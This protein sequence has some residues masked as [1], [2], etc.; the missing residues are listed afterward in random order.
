MRSVSLRSAGASRLR[1]FERV[2]R[3]GP[4]AR[5]R[6]I[7]GHTLKLLP[8]RHVQV[9]GDSVDRPF[10][11]HS[12]RVAK[13]GEQNGANENRVLEATDGLGG[14]G[15]IGDLEGAVLDK[16]DKR[17]R[18]VLR[19]ILECRLARRLHRKRRTNA[20]WKDINRV[21]GSS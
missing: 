1:N 14:K 19:E 4:N 6:V 8:R 15:Q 20:L 7:S 18:M 2:P 9:V 17:I 13:K 16:D 5:A 11:N 12:R 21:G 3:G 10:T